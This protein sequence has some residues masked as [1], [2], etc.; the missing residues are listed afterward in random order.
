MEI[1]RRSNGLLCVQEIVCDLRSMRMQHCVMCRQFGSR[2]VFVE[3]RGK[4]T[5]YNAGLQSS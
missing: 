3:I 4:G 1:C 2:S 5:D